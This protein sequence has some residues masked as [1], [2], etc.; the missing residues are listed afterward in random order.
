MGL[1]SDPNGRSEKLLQTME[2]G[3]AAAEEQA[4]ERALSEV[5]EALPEELDQR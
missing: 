4:G 5:M 2:L 1:G 3:R